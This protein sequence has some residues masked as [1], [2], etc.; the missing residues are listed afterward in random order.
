MTRKFFL[1][2]NAT[3]L[4]FLVGS[5]TNL[6]PIF[7]LS[8]HQHH[9]LVARPGMARSCGAKFQVLRCLA[10]LAAFVTQRAEKLR[11]SPVSKLNFH[12]DIEKMRKRLGSWNPELLGKRAIGA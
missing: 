4:W 11:A 3:N 5:V 6:S 7:S 2:R 10:V 8:L 9:F 1:K 12:I